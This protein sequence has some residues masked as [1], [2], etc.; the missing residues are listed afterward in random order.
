M[1]AKLLPQLLFGLGLNEVGRWCVGVLPLVLR[2][3]RGATRSWKGGARRRGPGT[4]SQAPSAAQPSPL[5]TSAPVGGS[6]ASVGKL[7][8]WSQPGGGTSSSGISTTAT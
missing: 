8:H 7:T 6:E 2:M 5:T 4:I 1:V 3:C